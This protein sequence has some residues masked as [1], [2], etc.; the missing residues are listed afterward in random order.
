MFNVQGRELT[1]EGMGMDLFRWATE[2]RELQLMEGQ[3]HPKN[4]LSYQRCILILSFSLGQ[5]HPGTDRD[6]LT[7]T[8]TTTTK[9]LF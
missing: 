7:T 9:Q 5:P 8:T 2:V 1:V 6:S 3:S 4:L